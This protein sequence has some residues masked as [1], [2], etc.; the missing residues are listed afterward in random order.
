M[1]ILGWYIAITVLVMVGISFVA[2]YSVL[3]AA[4]SS[5]S[6]P[7]SLF[8]KHRE[9][10]ITTAIWLT[11]K[12]AAIWPYYVYLQLREQVEEDLKDILQ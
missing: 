12:T 4:R 7:Y 3:E 1:G 2:V 10:I 6:H 11:L 8:D 5:G 9:K